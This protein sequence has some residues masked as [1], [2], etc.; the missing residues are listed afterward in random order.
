[1]VFIIRNWRCLRCEPRL[2]R[3]RQTWWTHLSGDLKVFVWPPLYSWHHLLMMS[4]CWGQ[5]N[6]FPRLFPNRR[7]L[8]HWC[9]SN[10][11]SASAGSG[12]L[13]HHRSIVGSICHSW[14][15]KE[16]EPVSWNS[17]ATKMFSEGWAL[18]ATRTPSSSLD[19]A[20]VLSQLAG[21]V[22]LKR[23]LREKTHQ[24]QRLE[25]GKEAQGGEAW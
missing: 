6:L 7:A 11:V 17:P 15:E 9:L 8:G 3:W 20:V 4:G 1:M 22:H 25:L 13:D 10:C 24:S 14:L 16:R 21:Q 18:V 12:Y 23:F 2:L 5:L 19:V